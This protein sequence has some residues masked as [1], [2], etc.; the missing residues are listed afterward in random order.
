MAKSATSDLEKVL[1]LLVASAE[2]RLA[3]LPKK[4]AAAAR[5]KIRQIADATA[6]R[7]SRK[8]SG[9][10]RTAVRRDSK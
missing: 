10:A 5:K 8:P 7:G 2:K 9:A 4:E 3:H 1:K 6:S